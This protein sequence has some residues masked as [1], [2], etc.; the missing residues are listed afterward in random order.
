MASCA[1]CAI[2]ALQAA[3]VVAQAGGV[4]MYVEGSTFLCIQCCFMHSADWGSVKAHFCKGVVHRLALVLLVLLK[5]HHRREGRG[6][7]DQLCVTDPLRQ[8]AFQ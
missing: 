2:G 5:G 1:G 4:C 6:A 3:A 8:P 7:R